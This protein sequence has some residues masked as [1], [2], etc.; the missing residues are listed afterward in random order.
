MIEE[1]SA[2][3][4]WDLVCINV[5]ARYGIRWI[6]KSSAAKFW[7][8]HDTD[9]GVVHNYLFHPEGADGFAGAIYGHVSRPRRL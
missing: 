2:I 8:W 6:A 4:F 3:S 9:A 5:M 1:K 7:L